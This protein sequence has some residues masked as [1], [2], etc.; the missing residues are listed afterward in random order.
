MN[1]SYG[2]M[3]SYILII[4]FLLVFLRVDNHGH[5]VPI[6]TVLATHQTV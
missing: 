6:G 4:E 2:A 3:Y 1:Y 5:R